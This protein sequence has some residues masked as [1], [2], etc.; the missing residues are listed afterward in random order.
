M[1]AGK[2]WT[3][4]GDC[5]QWGVQL[6]SIDLASKV[7]Q[8]H[9]APPTL[10]FCIG[11]ADAPHDTDRLLA[12]TDGQQPGDGRGGMRMT[13]ERHGVQPSAATDTIG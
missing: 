1:A 5:E 6:V 11:L 2:L 8:I 7:V 10:R 13:G 12:Y 4:T 9:D 3:S